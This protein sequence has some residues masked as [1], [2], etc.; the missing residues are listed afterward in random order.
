MSNPAAAQRILLCGHKSYAASGLVE[1]LRSQGHEVF[2]FSRGRD[3]QADH[4]ITGSVFT[5]HENPALRQPFDI[6]INYILL[7]DE[8]VAPNEQFIDS[9][10][11][12]IKQSGVKRLIHI[13]SVSVYSGDVRNVN[14]SS[15]VETNPAKKGS[16]GGLK[17]A[18]DQYIVNH[19]PADL[20]VQF[21]RP[22]FVLAP[23][24]ISPMVGMA[25]K[26]PWNQLLVLGAADNSLPVIRRDLLNQAVAA[27]VKD[28]SAKNGEVYLCFDTN[29]PTRKEWLRGCCTILGSGTRVISLP[30][31]M[32][33]TLA[34]GAG[35]VATILRMKMKPYRLIRNTL[36]TQKFDSTQ[37]QR[38][39]GIDFSTDWR[40]ELPGAMDAQEQNY[41]FAHQRATL[42]N[43]AAK[44]VTILGYGGIVRQ[45]HLPALKRL[46][47][48]GRIDAYDVKAG[49]DEQTNQPI[50][51]VADAKLDPTDLVVIASPGKYH[52]AAIPLLRQTEAPVLIEKPLC[53]TDREL[54][55]W[56][57]LTK[58]RK[59]RVM[60]CHNYRFKENVLK[61]LEHLALYN[62][63]KIRQ[64]DLVFQSLPVSF[65]FPAW[66]RD[67]RG[68][69]TLLIEYALH[70]LDVACMFWPGKWEVKDIRYELNP[71]GQTS[72]IEGRLA[73]PNYTI[74]FLLRQ[75]F[76]PRKARILCTF[77]NYATSLG[78][79]PDTFVPHMA[80]DGFGLYKLESKR[81]F[82]A[83][84]AKVVDKLTNRDSDIS[85]PVA[86]LGATGQLSELGDSA[87]VARLEHFYRML[88]EVSRAVYGS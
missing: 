66:R 73:C 78:F 80:G 7:K 45:K 28:E 57:E 63:G 55:E 85:H 74:N 29:S 2:T 83:T 21:V 6:V 10:L 49:T 54:D 48:N 65:H 62:S 17:V 32:W 36:R 68:A 40:K 81:S 33:M 51:A 13:S 30:K 53:Y 47:F 41:Q 20:K 67:E 76:M 4:S 75:G 16:Y 22:G 39:L 27:I 50:K 72:L 64:V 34:M 3:G 25:A 14:E 43:I 88:F 79:F 26:L 59:G 38:R 71:A 5:M 23:G 18:A 24:L 52:N 42:G 58:T 8:T 12:F 46:N 9:L 19:A 84:G 35:M 69:Q 44:A 15:P 11:K 87:T 37:T 1:L 56:L 61:M 70:Y 82:W 86:F 77:Q 31:F 60:I